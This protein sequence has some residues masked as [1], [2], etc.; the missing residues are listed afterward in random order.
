MRILNVLHGI[1]APKKISNCMKKLISKILA[2]TICKSFLHFRKKNVSFISC[3]LLSA[4]AFF[5]RQTTGK[6][7]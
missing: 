3:L 4:P 1:T 5:I 7:F 6:L 2:S